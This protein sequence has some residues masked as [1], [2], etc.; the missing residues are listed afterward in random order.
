MAP[1]LSEVANV[2]TAEIKFLHGE[3]VR[4][5]VSTYEQEVKKRIESRTEGPLSKFLPTV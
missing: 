3:E 2:D 1:T 4:E 5:I